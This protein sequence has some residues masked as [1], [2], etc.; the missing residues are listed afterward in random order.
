MSLN[1]FQVAD[2]AA[3]SNMAKQFD[4]EIDAEELAIDPI[5][6]FRFM[7]EQVVGAAGAMYLREIAAHELLSASQEV[8]LAQQLELG[9]AAG[10]ELATADD[11]LDADRR[12]ELEQQANAGDRARQRLIECNLRLVVSVARRYIGRGLPFLDLVQ[13]GNIGL[14]TG[15]DKYDWTRGFRLSTYVYWWIRQAMS[16][17]ISDQSRSV[18]LPGHV[19]EFLA[20]SARAERELAAE[21]GHDPTVEELAVYLDVDPQRIT[22]ARQAARSPVSLETPVGED[23]TFTQGDLIR[24]EA[25]TDAAHRSSEASEVSELLE[26]ALDQLSPRER[27]I[28]RHRF[29]LDSG[30]ERSLRELSRELGLSSER[31]RQIER[32]ALSKLRSMPRFGR[33][34]Q[35]YA[36]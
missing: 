26:S 33:E 13:E 34:L 12:Q 35:T 30:E 31:I 4:T 28:L 10:H 3:A 23:S 21:L 15:I 1:E 6:V 14:Q 16:R 19:I 2:E 9:K 27:H 11:T 5:G 17:A 32:G 20:S 24:D 36:A 8:L 7:S 22:E 25:A 18:R 29:G